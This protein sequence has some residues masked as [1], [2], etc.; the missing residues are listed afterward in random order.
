V[1][2]V[3]SL[4]PG[5]AAQGFWAQLP[6]F[7]SVVKVGAMRCDAMRCD[8]MQCDAMHMRACV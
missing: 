7:L 4:F 5:V 3:L 1:E 6:Q 8:A 2:H